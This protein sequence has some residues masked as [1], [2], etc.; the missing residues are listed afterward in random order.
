MPAEW[1]K[2]DA[3]WLAWPK[4]PNTFPPRILDKVESIY[5]Q[6]ISNLSYAEQVKVLVD[7]HNIEEKARKL[8]ES[9]GYLESNVLFYKITS[10]D[11]WIRDYGPIFLLNRKTG[12]KAGVKW[13]YNAYGNKYS[14]LLYDDTTGE[15]VLKASGVKAFRPK[16]VLEGGSIE[17]DG[18]GTLLTTEQC[19]LNKNRNPKMTRNQIENK[20][21]NFTGAES[22]VW[23]KGGIEGDD[24][25][26]HVDDFARFAPGNKILCCRSDFPGMDANVLKQNFSILQNA[27]DS[28]GQKFEII[29]LPMPKPLIN[30]EERRKLPA[31]YAN[32]YIGN[33]IILLPIFGDAN[34]F[35]AIEI[36][37]ESFPDREVVPIMARELVYGYGGIHCVTQQEPA[38]IQF[39]L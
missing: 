23:L 1:A 3:T 31:S 7:D 2:H 36:V 29:H 8:L 22:V 35:R 15:E 17:V 14:D 11:V 27:V 28:D 16:M 18:K 26:G 4:N 12:K 25:D 30:T 38:E 33:K 32:F 24:T 9:S 39:D 21:K 34:D 10:A 19:L 20:V 6:I 5:C 37:S 13:S